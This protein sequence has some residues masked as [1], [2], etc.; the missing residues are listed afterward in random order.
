MQKI[1]PFQVNRQQLP[2]FD[3]QTREDNVR[4]HTQA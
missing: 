1:L 3:D 4:E 2:L